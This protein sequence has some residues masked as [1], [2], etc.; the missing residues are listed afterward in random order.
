VNL[1]RA[2]SN[3]VSIKGSC[4]NKLWQAADIGVPLVAA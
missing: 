2:R 1:P 4:F 3:L